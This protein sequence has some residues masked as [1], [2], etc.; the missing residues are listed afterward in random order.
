MHRR[1]TAAAAA[2]A[3]RR[4]CSQRPPPPPDR[5]LAFLRSELEDLDLSRAPAQPPSREQWQVTQEPGSGGARAG[6]KPVAVDIAHPWPEWV[7]LMEFL[8]HKGHLDPSAFAGAAPSKDSNL[9]RTACLRFGRERPEI[10]RYL[11]RWDIQVALRGGCPSIDRKVINSGKRLRAHVGLDEGEVCSQCNLRG[12]CERAYVRARKEE[13]GR[14]VDVMRILLTYG[15][16]IITGNVGNKACLNKTVKE[17]I[18]KLLNEVV[19]LDSK[20]PGSTTDKAAQRMSKGQ[21]AVPVKQGDWNCPKCNFLNFAKNIKCLRCDGEFQERYH[22]MHED[23]DHL[24]LKKG[25]WICKRCNFLNFAKNTRCLQCHDKPT[26]R[27][28]SP[29]EWECPSCNY[30]NFKRNAFCLKC[31]WKRPKALNDQDTIE[32]HRDLEQNKHPAISFVQDGIQPTLRKRQL[33]QKRAPLSDEDSDFWSSEEAGNDDD[34]DNENSM[35]PMHRD[36]KFLDSFPIVG[37]RSA[38][39]QEPLEREK[40]KEEMSRGNQ[41]LPGEASE[42][43]NRPSPRVPRSM[44]MLESEDD[45]DEISSW[46]SGANSSRNLKR[47]NFRENMMGVA[48]KLLAGSRVIIPIY[49]L[50]TWAPSSG[51]SPVLCGSASLLLFLPPLSRKKAFFASRGA[52]DIP[53]PRGSATAESIQRSSGGQEERRPKLEVEDGLAMGSEGS[54]PVV[55]PRNF[56]LLEEL[57]RGEKGIGDGTVSYGMDDADDIYMRSWTG[58]IIGPPNTVHEGRIYQ[59]KLFCDTDYPDKPPTVRF[60][61]RVN[62]TCVNQETGMVDPRRFPMLGNWKREHTMEDI[63]ISLKKEM[64]TPQNRRLHQPHEGTDDQRVEQ[65]GLAARCV[66]M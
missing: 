23:Q 16:D 43:S 49:H 9:V 32:P 57:E 11:S 35:L 25:D 22:L 3:L 61:A 15:L 65:K 41:G 27:L 34:D 19:E 38:T 54:A 63:L 26:N 56:R 8:L 10:V 14:T 20:G 24:P 28:L 59:L 62:M 29:G 51:P 33:V 12:S 47:Y 50:A 2:T 17:S 45:D 58:T 52:S 1:L 44:E 60:Q 37:G 40:W 53:C 42:E 39:S 46:F 55:V 21:S 6:D 13:V 64:S 18:K 5:R 66:V 4:F 30:L 7:A 48:R 31:G 36:Y